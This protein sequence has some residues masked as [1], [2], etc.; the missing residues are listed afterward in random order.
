MRL[1]HRL[2]FLLLLVAMQAHAATN[3]LVPIDLPSALRLA[4]A[5]NLDL[6]I[7]R[8][9]LAEAKANYEGTLWQFFPWISPGIS[10]KRHDDLI[11]NVE[12]NIIDVHK[13]SY[14][15]G[16]SLIGQLDL[17]D[18]IYRRLASRQLVKATDFALETQ[19]QD[20]ILAAAYG[21]FDL[22]RSRLS[23]GVAR[24]AVAISTNYSAQL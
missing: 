13:D 7:A 24:Q 3:E 12:G 10:Y 2:S 22:A 6:R 18:A 11:Q 1:I 5:Q 4:G 17:G 9:R 20:A 15:V 23:V 8:E 19:R 14:S 21:Y 16:P